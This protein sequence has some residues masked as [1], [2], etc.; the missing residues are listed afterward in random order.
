MAEFDWKQLEEAKANLIKK[1][2]AIKKSFVQMPGGQPADGGAASGVPPEAAGVPPEMAGAGAPPDAAGVPPEMAAAMAG[3][4]MG[5]DAATAGMLGIPAA[6]TPAPDAGA[7]AGAGGAAEPTITITI[8]QLID[9]IKKLAG[10]S[11]MLGPGVAP[12]AATP[13][14]QAA[15]GADAI[16]AAVVE[17][18]GDMGLTR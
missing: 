11:K 17:A 8:G 13:A 12:E 7:G 5:V 10:V 14:Q 3:A 6:P 16:K 4:P 1:A 9:L 2:E 15:P 18:L